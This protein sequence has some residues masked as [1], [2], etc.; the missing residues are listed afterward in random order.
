MTAKHTAKTVYAKG[1]AALEGHGMFGCEVQYLMAIVYGR[2][3][4]YFS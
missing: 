2:F 1:I 4:D 3:I